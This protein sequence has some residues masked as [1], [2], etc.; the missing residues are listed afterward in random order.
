MSEV[1]IYKLTS[2]PWKKVFPKLLEGVLNKGNRV[3]VFCIDGSIK[4]LDDLLWTYE[5]LSFLPHGTSEDPHS[6]GHP[7]ILSSKP[8]AINGAKV[9]AIA[10]DKVPDNFYEY[11]KI[12]CVFDSTQYGSIEPFLKQCDDKKIQKSFFVQNSNGAWD[13]VENLS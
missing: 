10:N 13:K 2:N 6:E 5:Q 1:V 8:F 3:H 9:L 12:L 4:E 11:E 7:I